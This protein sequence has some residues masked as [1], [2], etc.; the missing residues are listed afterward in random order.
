M[1][2]NFHINS[3]GSLRKVI[4]PFTRN[5][6]WRT[7]VRVMGTGRESAA[8]RFTEKKA[9]RS[10]ALKLPE[11]AL[12]GSSPHAEL[13]LSSAHQWFYTLINKTCPCVVFTGANRAVKV[14]FFSSFWL[15]WFS[16]FKR[17]WSDIVYE[18]WCMRW[19][20]MSVNDWL[21]SSWLLRL[22]WSIRN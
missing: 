21:P 18:K 3:M 4:V 14:F 13:L 8:K 22:I 5:G 17:V 19:H 10:S 12:Q 15:L 20:Q 1:E 7:S 11:P 16:V 2:T 6:A 9:F